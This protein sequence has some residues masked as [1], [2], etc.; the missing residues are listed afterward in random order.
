L[1]FHNKKVIKRVRYLFSGVVQGV[2]FRPFIYRLAVK[3]SLRGFVQNRPDG[4]LVEV[5]GSA[6]AIDSFL[7]GVRQEL[8]P[9]A[10]VTNISSKDIA[11]QLDDNF[12]IIES[13]RRGDGDVHISPDIAICRDCLK[14]LFDPLDRRYRF[15][16]INCT[17]CGPRLTI[18]KAIPYDRIN[19]SMACFPLCPQC[20]AEYENPADR[21]FHAE[22]NA[23]PLCGPKIQL[24]DETGNKV[25]T[26][27]PI[28]MAIGLLKEGKI[29]A[30][31]GLGGFHLSVDAGS[32]EAVKRLRSRKFREEKPMAIMV[33]NLENVKR[34]ANVNEEEEKLLSSPQRPIVLLK[35]KKGTTISEQVAPGVPNL[36]V[37]LP[38]TPLHYLL[39]EKDFAALVMTSANQ[40]DEPICI[41]NREAVTR[42]KEIA[43][44]F[45]IH[46][47]DILVRC[48]DSIVMFAGGKQQLLRRSRG[49]VPK[50]I[51]LRDSF[52]DVL[53]LGPQ[54]K[55][56]QCIVKGNFAF[57]SPHIGDMETPQARDFF[58]ES[59][60]LMKKITE[61]NPEVI[62]C[63]YHP[64][65]YSTKVAEELTGVK[66]VRVQHHHAHIVSCMAENKISG[67]VIGLAMDGTGYGLDGNAWGGEFLVVNETEFK[68]LGHLQYFVLPG[69]E[70]AIHEPWR[71]AASLL[72]LAY[73]QSWPDM[74]A[75]LGILPPGL[76]SKVLDKIIKNK[77]NSPMTSG[78]GRLFD[79]VAAII[80]LRKTV[81]FEGQAAMEL[82]GLSDQEAGDSFP[83]AILADGENCFILDISSTIRAIVNNLLA[84]KS[85]K[86]ISSSFHRTLAVAF[87]A[88]CERIRE[89]TGIDRVCLS[90]GCFQNKILL[91]GS[92]TQLESADFVVYH[93]KQVPTNDGGIALG[94]A[95]I[96]GAIAKK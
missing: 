7:V 91:K 27:E 80:G 34:F 83:F 76:D 57:L 28:K 4:V 12:R 65:Y 33:R 13:E 73:G 90:G 63:D 52:P 30:I 66:V 38:Y 82:E 44:Y 25:N 64:A 46:N 53:A 9:L 70:K 79:G 96:A 19:T 51:V 45:L 71:I 92:I 81:S 47:R 3:N 29:L 67:D 8:P 1:E 18:I 11:I 39:L 35:K 85:K 54:L 26:D 77:I 2:G 95:V 61:S 22:P 20:Q 49:F 94:Q 75:Q 37:M 36:G 86:E 15:P 50:P 10:D 88:M 87:A 69:G 24:L 16:F 55:A 74:A 56:T 93:H 60:T 58:Q 41:S 42:L 43:D 68:R 84:G 62:A 72:A 17:N 5:Q 6:A 32:D 78:L 23:C 89:K 21:R 14:E 48:D 40:I 31:K 59:L